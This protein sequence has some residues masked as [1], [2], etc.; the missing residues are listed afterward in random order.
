ML[1]AQGN[2]L[3]KTIFFIA[4]QIGDSASLKGKLFK[5]CDA[6]MATKYSLPENVEK[7]ENQLLDLSLE[8]K[9]IEKVRKETE[10]QLKAQ[11]EWFSQTNQSGTFSN[12]EELRIALLKEKSI[13]EALDTMLL[14]E[15]IFYGKFW[16]TMEY[17]DEVRKVLETLP[18]TSRGRLTS[19]PKIEFK[20]YKDTGY[21]PPTHFK[22]NCF[23]QTSQV[24]TDTYEVPKYREVNPALSTMITFPFQYGVMFG[25]IGHG[26]LFFLFGLF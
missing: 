8:M 26:A 21:E 2:P 7:M 14:K 17:E 5:I 19:K 25:D 23:T 13:Y 20:N 10:D 1:D 11:L 22:V 12:I 4:Y 18:A 6:F 16:T 24:I 15:N 9:N 3:R